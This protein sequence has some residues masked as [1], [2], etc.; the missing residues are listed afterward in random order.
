M[1]IGASRV[2]ALSSYQSLPFPPPA[3]LI[4]YEF[5]DGG[6]I[7]AADS[8]G[9]NNIG[10]FTESV[11]ESPNWVTSPANGVLFTAT[12]TDI[13][14]APNMFQGSTPDEVMIAIRCNATNTGINQRAVAFRLNGMFFINSENISHFD[15]FNRDRS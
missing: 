7:H 13:L 15:I 10:V 11:P 12:N 3:A 5:N 8:S 6:G 4:I 9:N 1:T 2:A 14:R